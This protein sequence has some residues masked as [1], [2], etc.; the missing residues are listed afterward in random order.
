[1]EVSLFDFELPEERIALRPASPR[2]SARMLVI[3]TDG[4]LEHRQ[5]RD[6]PDYMRAGDA[7]VVNDTRVMP[8]RLYGVRLRESGPAKIG[9]LL[10]RRLDASRFAVLARPARKLAPGDALDFDGLLARVAV[11][12]E[13]G[14]AEIVFTLSGV[15]LDTALAARGEMPL[16]PYIAGKRRPD[17]RDREDYQT[18][19]ARDGGNSG[20]RDSACGS[21]YVFARHR[22]GYGT[23]PHARRERY[24]KPGD[25][26]TLERG[27]HGRGADCGGGH[28]VVAHAGKRSFARRHT[29]PVPWGNRHLHHARLSIPGHRRAVHQFPSSAFHPVHAGERF[30][31]IGFN[32]ARLRGSSRARLPLLFLRRCLF[33]NSHAGLKRVRTLPE[34]N[35]GP[36]DDR[37]IDQRRPLRGIFQI[38]SEPFDQMLLGFGISPKSAD[39]SKARNPGLHP[40]A[41]IEI[42]NKVVV[43]ACACLGPLGMRPRTDQRHV[44]C[45]DIEQLW[46]FI[47]AGAS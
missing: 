16:P 5:V 31:G 40:V 7:L 25:G 13:N 23:S 4:R 46:K 28:N 44:A 20:S 21:G 36:N 43:Q 10:H 17:A 3:H 24:L 9:I 41:G 38:Q 35:D 29:P 33:V 37:D 1:M 18:I 34:M 8:A 27:A 6:L 14:E 22:L 45:Q 32:E 12:G 15:A 39:L 26:D 11:R 19:Y 2:D 47:R 30:Y 42:G